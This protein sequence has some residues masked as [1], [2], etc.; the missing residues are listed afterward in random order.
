MSN[1]KQPRREP[2]KPRLVHVHWLSRESDAVSAE[3]LD[4]SSAGLFVVPT[5]DLPESLGKDDIVWI[6]IPQPDGNKT[7]TGKVRSATE[8]ARAGRLAKVSGITSVNN[9]ISGAGSVTIL[10]TNLVTLT[11]TDTRGASNSCGALAIVLDRTPPVL[12]CP[13]NIVVTNAHDSA[14]SIVTFS[15][16]VWDNCSGVGT[17]VCTPPS[18]SAFAVGAHNVSVIARD[19]AGN[20]SRGSFTVTVTASDGTPIERWITL[21]PGHGHG[22]VVHARKD[23]L[24]N[25]CAVSASALFMQ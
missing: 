5:G 14:T 8:K 20:L 3:L 9:L 17:P 11:V 13:A 2:R 4:V 16:T 15:P 6:V 25:V 18:G 10:G 21:N 1:H 7:L 12:T 24:P 23:Y 19:A 22:I